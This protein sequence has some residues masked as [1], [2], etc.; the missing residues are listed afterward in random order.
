MHIIK[1]TGWRTE[2]G[3]G[4]GGVRTILKS[5]ERGVPKRGGGCGKTRRNKGGGG[6]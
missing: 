2:G 5:K 3:G 4:E 6:A 1:Q